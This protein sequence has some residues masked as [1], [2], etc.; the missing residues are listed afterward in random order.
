MAAMAVGEVVST[1]EQYRA[2]QDKLEE[3]T[4]CPICRE[5]YKQPKILSCHHTFCCQ[6][7]QSYFMQTPGDSSPCPLCR[8][9]FYPPEGHVSNLPTST[10]MQ[11]VVMMIDR[12]SPITK[13]DCMVCKN[14][15]NDAGFMCVE[16]D[17]QMCDS[18]RNIHEMFRTDSHNLL[19]LDEIHD[20]PIISVIAGKKTSRTC[21]DHKGQILEHLCLSCNVPMCSECKT[22]SHYQHRAQNINH[23]AEETR[24]IIR[25][26]QKGSNPEINRLTENIT[27]IK[28]LSTSMQISTD[29]MK[30]EV[31]TMTDSLIKALRE[32]ERKLLHDIETDAML[33]Q[34]ELKT[35]EDATELRLTSEL[36][37]LDYVKSLE[38]FGNVTQLSVAKETIRKRM[39]DNKG[40][41]I[42]ALPESCRCNR[43]FRR[44]DIFRNILHSEDLG[45]IETLQRTPPPIPPRMNCTQ[46]R[47]EPPVPT[48]PANGNPIVPPPR[49]PRPEVTS[50][51]ETSVKQVAEIDNEYTN[52]KEFLWRETD[53]DRSNSPPTSPKKY[54]QNDT[55]KSS[56]SKRPLPPPPNPHASRSSMS[57]AGSE[58]LKVCPETPKQRLRRAMSDSQLL[59]EASV[60]SDLSYPNLTS[61]HVSFNA[62]VKISGL[63]ITRKDDVI[64]VSN[65]SK[66]CLVFNQLGNLKNEISDGL[67]N[68]WDVAV[69]VINDDLKDVV[70]LTDTGVKSGEGNVKEYRLDGTFVRTLVSKL[71]KPHGITTSADGDVIYVCDAEDSSIIALSPQRGKKPRKIKQNMLGKNLF[72]C[73][74]YVSVTTGGEIIV[75]DFH[76]GKLVGIDEKSYKLYKK[77]YTSYKPKKSKNAMEFRPAMSCVDSESNI[78]VVDQISNCIYVWAT[79]QDPKRIAIP[80]SIDITRPVALAFDSSGALWIGSRKGAL[81]KVHFNY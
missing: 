9:L 56:P 65:N 81:V 7:L 48:S 28:S 33:R 32:K 36:T 70:Y 77:S 78:F 3:L 18:C 69:S 43:K 26:I 23:A 27:D 31:R 29:A 37:F 30:D 20:A 68:P 14:S 24:N 39:E 2:L 19:R 73:P 66:K 57:F 42:P 54:N 75:S 5:R 34:K 47:F 50:S 52:P 44:S 53:S 67:V 71:R 8:S 62:K 11:D 76:A 22:T 51:D 49:D 63:A 46:T 25:M 17:L 59:D 55:K 15:N 4:T 16:C 12:K 13:K 1:T 21:D 58:Y 41:T 38:T 64:V 40:Q 72:I 61:G 60:E 79:S 10:F 74:W 45:S 35:I 6:C 80:P